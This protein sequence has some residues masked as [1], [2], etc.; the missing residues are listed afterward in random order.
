MNLSIVIV[1]K[2]EERNIRDCLNTAKW[3]DE[4]IVVDAYSTDRTID[5]VREFTEKIYQRPWEGF[6]IQ[7]NFAMQK[8]TCPWI[9][10]L[11]SDERISPA[12]SDEIQEVIRSSPLTIAGYQLARKNYYYG[13]WMKAGGCYPDY[14]LRLLR[15]GSG[16][17][18]DAEPHN[19]MI[20][21]GEMGT[22]K[23]PLDHLTCPTVGYQL[24][25]TPNF[26]RLAAKEKFKIKKTVAWY[27]LFFPPLA[28]FL[29][30]YLSKGSWKEGI[31]G[32]IYS[33]FASLY[34]FLKYAKLW[35]MIHV[36]CNKLE[37]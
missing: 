9:F 21:K 6:G 37:H 32:F 15:N 29:K 27:D 7:K 20:L 18:D 14:Q 5:I 23:T 16:Y 33:G 34:T 30:M 2:N 10:I 25:K 1:T 4:I 3:A 24:R 8:A 13:R 35:E 31:T 26:S 17:L 12:L 19:K 11:D 28:T 36:R 22:L